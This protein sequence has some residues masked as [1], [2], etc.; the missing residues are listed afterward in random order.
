MEMGNGKNI[1]WEHDVLIS[2]AGSEQNSTTCLSF[3]S[4]TFHYK[5]P[6][7]KTDRHLSVIIAN[8]INLRLAPRKEAKRIVLLFIFK[9]LP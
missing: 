2:K 6:T 3:S 8:N 5:L 7:I 1:G 9:K 4:F